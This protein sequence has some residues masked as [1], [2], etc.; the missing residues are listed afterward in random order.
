MKKQKKGRK[1]E[2]VLE[3]EVSGEFGCFVKIGLET[4][5][6]RADQIEVLVVEVF[7]IYPSL[8]Q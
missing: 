7:L 6:M 1:K 5:N 4:R 3:V 2:K 8:Q